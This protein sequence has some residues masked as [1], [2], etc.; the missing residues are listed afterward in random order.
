M[1]SWLTERDLRRLHKQGAKYYPAEAKLTP[2][3]RDFAR[4]LQLSAGST[5]SPAVIALA[6]DHG[7][8]QLKESLKKS[9]IKAG[10]KIQDLGCHSADSVDYPDYAAAV[11][12]QVVC[13]KA[14]FG[15]MI[16]TYGTASAIAANKINGVRAAFCPSIEIAVSARSHNDANVLTLG[17]KMDR[18]EAEQI[19][20]AFLK[21]PFQGGRHLRRVEKIQALER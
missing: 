6:C 11:G 17:G 20:L 21:E 16:D 9:L 8:F 12:K 3:A 7:G 10:Y 13:G 15:I 14:G 4:R 1:T 19:A 18:N 2:A 5:A